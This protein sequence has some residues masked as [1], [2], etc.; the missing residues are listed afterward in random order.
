MAFSYR[1][2][3]FAE[4]VDFDHGGRDVLHLL[5]GSGR[6]AQV[7]L[8][9]GWMSVWMPLS[10]VLAFESQGSHWTLGKDHVLV[11]REGRLRTGNRTPCWWLGMAGSMPA[12]VSRFGVRHGAENSVFPYEGHC[13]RELRRLL[14]R[15]MRVAR[16]GIGAGADLDALADAFCAALIDSQ[17]ELAQRLER[18]SGR[19]LQ[20][21]RQTLL[22]LL[23][24]QQLIR[25]NDEGKLDLLQL[26]R[27]AN[28][29]PCHL[30][31]MYREVFGET[32]SEYA[33]RLRLERAWRLVRETRMPICEITEALGFES[34]SAFCRAFKTN[35]GA[36]TTQ[37][38]RLAVEATHVPGATYP[39]AHAA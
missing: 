21:R 37:A 31:R 5:R 4:Q 34:Q 36:T 28:Y 16:F 35:F 27:T 39:L 6:G 22:R 33:A 23:R 2:L 10:G 13:P 15:M 26:A 38:R 24:V 25:H 29:S 17:S 7:S 19:T 20:R 30:I 12:W 14:V 3:G 8:P 32:P 11:W 18:C 9:A 1:E